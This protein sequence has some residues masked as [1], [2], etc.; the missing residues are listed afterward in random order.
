MWIIVG[1][2]AT[3]TTSPTARETT[4]AHA[5]TNTI[6]NIEMQPPVYSPVDPELQKLKEETDRKKAC[7]A[8]QNRQEL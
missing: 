1:A 5:G 7:L 6:Q 2:A 8:S 4:L 3:L